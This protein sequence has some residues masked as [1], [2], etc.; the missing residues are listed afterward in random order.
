MPWTD[1]TRAQHQPNGLRDASDMTDRSGRGLP[2]R[3]LRAVIW[4]PQ[5]SGFAPSG[6]DHTLHSVQRM[7]MAGTAEGVSAVLG[8]SKLF[9]CLA[10][11]RKWQGIVKTPV[12][13]ARR[14]LGRKPSPTAAAIDGQSADHPCGRLARLRHRQTHLRPQAAYRHRHR[15]FVACRPCPLPWRCAVTLLE[16]VRLRFT[17]KTR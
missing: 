1:I 11:Y 16:R 7:P 2:G 3:C 12:R 10:R 4:A 13:Q 17:C 14:N 15:R 5:R 9:L 6:A 8:G